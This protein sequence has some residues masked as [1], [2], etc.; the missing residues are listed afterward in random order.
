MGEEVAPDVPAD[1]QSVGETAEVDLQVYFSILKE[2]QEHI[3]AA[4][5]KAGFFTA[6]NALLVGFLTREAEQ[7]GNA[8]WAAALFVVLAGLGALL[9]VSLVTWAFTIGFGKLAELSRVYYGRISQEY[10][11][12]PAK[13]ANDIRRMGDEEWASELAAFIVEASVVAAR[14]DRALTAAAWATLAGF[15][16]WA[17]VVVSFFFV[18]APR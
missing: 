7:L 6:A 16:S 17:L 1:P 2:V 9:S 14:K 10:R 3:R 8:H 13:Y 5:R 18:P 12:D 4:D 11:D 15:C